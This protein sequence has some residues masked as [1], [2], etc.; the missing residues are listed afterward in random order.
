MSF[1][2]RWGQTWN[3][4]NQQNPRGNKKKIPLITWREPLQSSD[5]SAVTIPKLS[6]P[7]PC[8]TPSTTIT[9]IRS[10]FARSSVDREG[11]KK[12]EITRLVY[13]V[14]DCLKPQIDTTK[15]HRLCHKSSVVSTTGDNG[16][17]TPIC[18]SD[19]FVGLAICHC[20]T[21]LLSQGDAACRL[22][23]K[24]YCGCIWN[25]H[26]TSGVRERLHFVVWQRCGSPVTL[27]VLFCVW[28]AGDRTCKLVP[29]GI[30]A[31]AWFKTLWRRHCG[32]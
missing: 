10:I 31:V 4:G 26:G 15:G 20:Q 16:R 5:S 12:K 9:A 22:I 1:S 19:P 11:T 21:M 18:S 2:R 23:V 27:W 32:W 14:T 8:T 29:V 30:V 7:W 3:Q 6:S 25:R 28:C 17:P 24:N 13:N